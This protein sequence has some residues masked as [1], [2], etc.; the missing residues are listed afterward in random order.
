MKVFFYGWLIVILGAVVL[1]VN[2]FPIYGFG[3]FLTPL[4]NEFGWQRGAISGAMSLGML[5]NGILSI[6]VGRLCD[7]YGPRIFVTVAGIFLGAGLLLM[8]QVNSLWQLYLIWGVSLGIGLSGTVIPI[9]STITRWFI[10]KRGLALSIPAT[11]FGVGAIITPLIIQKLISTV[12]WR[13]S[14][15]IIGFAPLLLTVPLA[16]FIRKSPEHMGLTPYQSRSAGKAGF[17]D[18]EVEKY[19]FYEAL[20]S[21][22]FW[23]LGIIGFG[24]GICLQ[25]ITIHIV[26]H[27]I[28]SGIGFTD[29]AIV[30]TIIGGS[31]IP[32]KFFCGFISDRIGSTR[33]LFLSM[34]LMTIS[35]ALLIFI[36]TIYMFYFF[37]VLFG[38]SY[39]LA[40]PLWTI[41]SADLFGVKSIG[42]ISGTLFFL[43]V[44]GGAI[45]APLSGWI[46]DATNSYTIAF[47]SITLIATVSVILNLILLRYKISSRTHNRVS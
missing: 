19:S 39:G 13:M 27:A 11:G 14:F 1:A 3:I 40:I 45:G 12:D 31:S 9:T 10:E 37:A 41:V 32:S 33:A 5:L 25:T 17:P 23:I 2:A 30:M 36:D 16:Q 46:F 42:I 8:S 6:P 34:M 47:I 21:K 7:R 44:T 22:K 26:P 35:L 43:S 20:K 29:A 18:N 24:F 4:T 38:F 28:D 15:T